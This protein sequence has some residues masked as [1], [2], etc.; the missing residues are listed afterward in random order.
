MTA[1]QR[2][3]VCGDIGLFFEMHSAS[4]GWADRIDLASLPNP[5]TAKESVL[6]DVE[7]ARALLESIRL[8][9]EYLVRRW[10]E[11]GADPNFVL[12]DAWPLLHVAVEHGQPAIVRLLVENGAELDAQDE[13]GRTALLWP[14]TA[15]V[16]PRGKREKL[17]KRPPAV[18]CSKWARGP[19]FRIKMG[20]RVSTS[21]RSTITSRPFNFLPREALEL[22]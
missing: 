9:S 12:P 16:T 22:P 20:R 8:E 3:E 14:S 2:W 19:I 5:S 6:N 18:C 4:F 11:R 1:G 13:S 21:P 7:K 15:K 17:L 10:L